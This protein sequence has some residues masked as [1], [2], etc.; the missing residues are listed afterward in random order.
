MSLLHA[1]FG[2]GGTISPFIST[3]FV[4]R[5]STQPNLLYTINLGVAVLTLAVEVFVFKGQTEEQLL[6]KAKAREES[7]VV[8]LPLGELVPPETVPRPEGSQ[9][10]GNATRLESSSSK[11]RRILSSPAVYVFIF[12]SFLYVS[13]PHSFTV[14]LISRLG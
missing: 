10:E 6:G 8:A 4:Q 3:P 5:Y 12:Y 9:T 11:M 13:L 2:L 7:G 1:F 14:T